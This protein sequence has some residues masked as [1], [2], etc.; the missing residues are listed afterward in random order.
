MFT[1]RT[2]AGCIEV[3]SYPLYLEDYGR[4]GF[5]ADSVQGGIFFK[6]GTDRMAILPG[7][8]SFE[9]IKSTDNTSDHDKQK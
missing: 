8:G 1:R 7:F 4:V 3:E 6:P 9:R 2:E 5:L